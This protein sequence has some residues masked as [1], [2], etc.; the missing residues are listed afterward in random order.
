MQSSTIVRIP[1]FP[2]PLLFRGFLSFRLGLRLSTNLFE[3]L[4]YAMHFSAGTAFRVEKSTR[5]CFLVHGKQGGQGKE[6]GF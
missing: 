5:A 4:R 2:A 1:L 6:E 3:T